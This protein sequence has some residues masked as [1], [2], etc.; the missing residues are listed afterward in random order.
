MKRGKYVAYAVGGVLLLC[1]A[2]FTGRHAGAASSTPG[3]VEDPL[4]TLSYLEGR[5]TEQGGYT[6][7][8]LKKGQSVVGSAG[9][10]LVLLSGSAT[11]NGAGVV[12]LTEGSLT[13][14]DL[15]LFLYHSYIVPEEKGG[16]TALS[17]CTLLVSGQYIVK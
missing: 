6:T 14:E 1:A 3:S 16:C 12:D 9:T 7:V 4:I 17:S 10:G 11:A 2:F 8:T 15:S 5:L 13:G